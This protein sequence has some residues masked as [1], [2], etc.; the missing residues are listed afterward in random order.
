MNR[1][2]SA[3]AMF[4]MAILAGSAE[5]QVSRVFV[6]VTGNDANVCSDVATPCRTIAGGVT[7]VDAQGEVIIIASGSYAGGTISKAVKVNAARGVVAF[8]GLPIIV[9]PGSGN[10]VV[11]RGLTI[12]AATPGSGYGITLSSGRL[13]VEECVIDG[14]NTGI[15]ANAGAER[16][17]VA[18]STIRNLLNYGIQTPAAASL[19]L[20]VENARFRDAFGAL[21]LEGSITALISNCEISGTG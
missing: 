16:L 21:A 7:Q 18:D 14:W 13:S 2:T 19:H 5:A 6:S 12:K 3:A 17:S 11:I 9:N 15:V 1:A 4:G 10:L 20:V 8:S